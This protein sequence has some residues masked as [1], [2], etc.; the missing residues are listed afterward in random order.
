MSARRLKRVILVLAAAALCACAAVGPDYRPSPEAVANRPEAGA[1]FTPVTAARSVGDAASAVVSNAPLPTYWWRLYDDPRLDGLIDDALAHNTDLRQAT[2]SLERAEAIER[3]TAG[4]RNPLISLEGGPSY[5]HLSGVE[6]LSPN[7]LPANTFNTGGTAALT[8]PLDV[9][10]QIRRSIEAAR[11]GRQSAQAAL[12]QVRVEVAAGT[13]RSYAEACA[14]GLRIEAAQRSVALQRETV[15]LSDRLQQAGRV[16]ITD[17]TRA[18]GLLEQLAAEVPPLEA[19]RQGA[20]FR[21][22]TLAGRVPQDFP[23]DLADCHAPPQVA[24]LI[25][26]GDGAALLRR[27]PDLRQAERNVAQATARIGVATGD[28]YP[29]IS[30]GLSATSIGTATDFAAKG[31][32]AW[33]VGPLIHWTIPNTG[34]ARARIAEAE[35]DT[36]ASLARFD[37]TVL[38]A[39]R[40]TEV[41][42]DDYAHE[43][44][45][46]AALQAALDANAVVADQARTLYV[47]GKTGYLELLDAQRSRATSEAALASSQAAL[48]DDQ[49]VLF[50]ALG[51]GWEVAPAQSSSD[52][53]I[54][55]IR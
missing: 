4:T 16:G 10:G 11:A 12:E 38:T 49:I 25:P 29:S 52:A 50:L 14:T 32:F 7:D 37:G 44:D 3:A 51:G 13:A 24:G 35:A 40:E 26:V 2:A 43:L 8:L 36:R 39:L 15:N 18:R 1:P 47:N 22:A 33:S 21:L 42:L 54:S 5:G 6:L 17:A 28:L 27:R 53:T 34:V 48:V 31:A 30:L 23:K 20:L 55:T 9:F 45:R 41:A 46:R 19:R